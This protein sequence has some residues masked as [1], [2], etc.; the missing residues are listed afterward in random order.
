MPRILL[1]GLFHETHTFLDGRTPPS[2]FAVRRGDELLA[3]RGDGSP[4]CGVLEVAAECGWELL[5]TIDMRATPSATVADEV[6]EAWWSEFRERAA[7]ETAGDIDGVFL[8]L[9][10]AMACETVPDVEGEILRRIRGIPALA[11][12]PLVGV[13]DLHGNISPATAQLSQGIVAYRN[14]PHTDSRD[15]AVR[16]AKLLDRILT[17][18]DRP[19]CLWEQPPVMW[20]PTGTGTADDPMRT[21]ETMAREIERL[22][23]Q[24]TAVNVFGGFSFADTPHTGVSF[25]AVTFGDPQIAAAELRRLSRWAIEHREQGNVLDPPLADVLPAI[26]RHVIA[27]ETPVLIVEPADNIGGGAP[28]DATTVLRALVE[29]RIADTAVIIND[30]LAVSHLGQCTLGN[31]R[32]ISIGGKGSRFTDGPLELD[33]E[34]LN[35]TDGKFDLE[36]RN[37][38]LASMAGVHIDMGPSAVVRV[39]DAAS[40][41]P[42]AGS[43]RNVRHAGIRILFTSRKT[44]PFDLGQ[45]RSQGI[46]PETLS[47]IGVKAAVAH[48]RAY[49]KIARHSYTVDIPGP[50]S[51]D[52]RTFPWQQ[53]RRPVFPLDEIA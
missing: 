51:S 1:A 31:T 18:G 5:P 15:S 52:L 48:R 4:L 26:Q 13:Y 3:A 21:L 34:L 22:R 35:R 16:A 27:G 9:H 30:P 40:V 20:P 38:H 46:D 7:A 8:V 19:V 45:W 12:V 49:D 23:P 37:S 50:C 32:R 43:F 47:V 44:P 25:S 36:D 29:N 11:D 17:T 14:N 24:I 41:G 2:A 42:E 33:V 53:I 39:A 28:G 6:L 10:G